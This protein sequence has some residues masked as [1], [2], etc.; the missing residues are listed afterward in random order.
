[1]YYFWSAQFSRGS[2]HL[3]KLSLTDFWPLFSW[4][5]QLSFFYPCPNADCTYN[6]D[7]AFI[8]CVCSVIKSSSFLWVKLKYRS[9]RFTCV[10]NTWWIKSRLATPF[11]DQ[12]CFG[13]TSILN[14][15][16]LHILSLYSIFISTYIYC[17]N[18]PIFPYWFTELAEKHSRG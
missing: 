17:L 9:P 1:M 4:G 7:D 14:I 6:M 8:S 3:H 2:H 15:P 16:R 12:S 10:I 5:F 13:W 18:I 11:W